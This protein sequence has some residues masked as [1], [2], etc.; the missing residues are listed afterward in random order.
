MIQMH[1]LLE[2]YELLRVFHSVD[3]AQQRYPEKLA[4]PLLI[5]LARPEVGE[6]CGCCLLYILHEIVLLVPVR[7][8]RL[9]C[10][11]L[12][13]GLSSAL[14]LLNMIQIRC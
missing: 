11:F 6:L 8:Y 7:L 12:L 5:S 9:P 13:S 2:L 10:V 1:L 14:C 3:I 4:L